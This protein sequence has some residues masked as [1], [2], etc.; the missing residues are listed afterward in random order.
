MSLVSRRSFLKSASALAAG[1]P[2]GGRGAA[3][4]AQRVVVVGAGLAGLVAA[5]ELMR[6]GHTVSVFEARDR[7]GGRIRTRRDAFGDGLYL[8]EGAVDF[9]DGY[10]LL[11]HYIDLLGLPVNEEALSP[12]PASARVYYVGGRRYLV[13]PGQEPDWPY[14]LSP[15][16]RRLG[17]QGLWAQY[18]L[19]AQQ[20][21]PA[22]FTAR[23]LD[24]AARK[25]DAHTVEDLLRKQGA[26]DAAILL[27]RRGFL[28]ADFDHVSALQE[29]FWKR[30][31]AGSHR[32]SRLTG[33]NE[34][35]PQALAERLAGRVHYGAELHSIAQD[36][37]RVRLGFAHASGAAEVEADRAVI[38]IPFSVLRG[39]NI[40]GSFSR[41]KRSAIAQL[42]YESATRVYLHSKT[43]FWEEA[44]LEGFANTDLTTGWV[45]DFSPG[46]AG[47][48]GILGTEVT[49]AD[50]QRLTSL[51]AAERVQLGLQNVAKVFPEITERFLGGASVC[52]DSEP[53][54]RGAWAYYAP[55]EMSTLFPHVATPEGRIHF[56]GE[57]T[58]PVYVM[59]G[60]AQSGARAA[61]EINA[62]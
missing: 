17:I 20:S 12:R 21:L 61:Q 48:A 50:S 45:L 54:A 42:R 53:Y 31:F 5:F 19:A 37:A 47:T 32:F 7:P 60:A 9:G 36:G 18:A 22:P 16:E 26:S 10:P 39:V 56:A 24:R 6:A 23:S 4:R 33:G 51:A 52:W 3:A 8:E 38:A 11:H 25:L 57:H 58:A 29:L 15:Q 62:L 44:G 27:L 1:L 55:G 35:L 30:F 14:A 46:Q 2:P 59:E 41:Q 43:R 40:D 28:G 13:P 34:R 49:G